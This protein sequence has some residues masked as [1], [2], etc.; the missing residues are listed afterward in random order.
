MISANHSFID[1]SRIYDVLIVGG[2]NAALCAAMTARENG[3]TVLLLEVAPKDFRG[4]NSR[5]TRNLRYLH[6]KANSHLT[7]PFL[8]DEFWDDL[9]RV[10]GGKTNEELARVTIRLSKDIG[11]WMEAHGCMFQPSMRGTL[12][13][14]RTNLVVV[15]L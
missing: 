5:H 14:S 3:A 2:G 8:E 13:L 10:T 12:S 1:M 6:D 7:G 15:K 11:N 9:Y 4:G